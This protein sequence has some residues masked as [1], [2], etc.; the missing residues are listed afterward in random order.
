[1]KKFYVLIDCSGSFFE[2][3]KKELQTY[4]VD[5]LFNASQGILKDV[6]VFSFFSWSDSIAP[7]SPAEPLTFGGNAAPEAFAKWLGTLEEEASVILLSDGNLHGDTEPL[8]DIIKL[9]KISVIP[10]AVGA[11][12]I[13]SLLSDFSVRHIVHDPVNLLTDVR[14][15]C[16]REGVV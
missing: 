13:V 9:K 14:H 4:L 7:Y 5:S 15:L 8:Y 3:G 16:E 1:M 6:A 11:D 2:S 12:A 10:F